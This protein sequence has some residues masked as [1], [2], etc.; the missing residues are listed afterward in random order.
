MAKVAGRCWPHDLPMISGSIMS[1][2]KTY[3]R[4][5]FVCEPRPGDFKFVDFD[6]HGTTDPAKVDSMMF[7]CPRSGKYCGSILVGFPQKPSISPSWKWDGNFNC[8]TLTPSINC[9]DGCKWHGHL[10]AGVFED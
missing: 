9:V 1:D 2:G 5:G 4:D 7:R 10:R 8:P 3:V 6:Y